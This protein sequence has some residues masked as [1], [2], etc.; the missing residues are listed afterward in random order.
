MPDLARIVPRTAI[1]SLLDAPDLPALV[2]RLAPEQLHRVIEQEGLEACAPLLVLATPA[3]LA[4][5]ADLD[6]WR[7]DRAGADASL[8]TGRFLE[9]LDVLLGQGTA[10][11]ARTLASMDAELVAAGIAACV[12]VLDW[13]AVSAYP[14]TDGELFEP[15]PSLDTSRAIELGS[16]L[17]VPREATPPEVILA[18]LRVL[19]EDA[20]ASF[21]DVMRRCRARSNEPTEVDGLDELPDATGQ[22]LHD[23][24]VGRG[25]RREARGFATPA[26][27]RAYLGAA[28]QARPAP[29]PPP[30]AACLGPAALAETRALAQLRGYLA[31]T[32]A[33]ADAH[34]ETLARLANTLLAGCALRGRAFTPREASDAAAATCNLGL[35]RWR[36][37]DGPPPSLAAAFE[38]GWS[39]LHRDV[40]LHAAE[41]LIAL[42][43]DLRARHAA[44]A[45]ELAELAQALTREWRAGTPW[46]ASGPLEILSALDAPAWAGLD[47]LI[48][49]CPVLHGGVAATL[50]PGAR[51]I[52]PD[53]FAFFADD[54]EIAQARRFVAG[55]AA[56]LA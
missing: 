27:A 4:Q 23:L 16:F 50:T 3:Q 9:W 32:A 54:G 2:P 22:A 35:A 40:A 13:A 31:A 34:A 7:S 5:L 53:A 37:S 24:A 45:D 1:Q 6:L 17:V 20:P 47:A 8:D 15:M 29:A 11:A 44:F 10:A 36:S 41:A 38:R 39:A 19:E 33:Q 55:L 30:V 51:R 14:H 21:A 26:E 52:E 46:R 49:E 18:A 56:T 12:R 42:L 28:R 25:L 48:A 43:P